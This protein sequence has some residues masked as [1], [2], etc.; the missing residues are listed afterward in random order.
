MHFHKEMFVEEFVCSWFDARGVCASIL[1]YILFE[2]QFVINK[3]GG[4]K[5]TKNLFPLYAHIS[6]PEVTVHQKEIQGK[7]CNTGCTH[8]YSLRCG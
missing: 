8:R 1:C 3:S 2:T 7:R 4:T 5:K 6:V